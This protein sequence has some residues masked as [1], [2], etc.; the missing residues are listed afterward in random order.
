M[1][2]HTFLQK[3]A[4]Y[5]YQTYQFKRWRKALHLDT[6]AFIYQQLFASVDGFA[7]SRLARMDHDAFDYTYGEIDFIAFI[8][9]LFLAKPNPD[10]VFYDL[11]SGIGTAVLACA[12]VYP[13]K[14]SI[15]IECLLPLH[16]AA[17]Q[18]KNKIKQ[19]A[20]YQHTASIIE[21]IHADFL[22]ASITD[23]TL[24]FINSTAYFG[25]TWDKI[26]QK[27]NTLPALETVLTLSKPL[28]C[29]D[30]KLI[31][32]TRINMS[33]GPVDAYIHQRVTP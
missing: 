24:I 27:L 29:P 15:G 19:Y 12:M 2:I 32:K 26:N 23:A 9:L 22:Q 5:T 25:E 20:T 10:T 33:W 3:I 30:F 13:I 4:P 7:L 8:A 21:F 31:Q 1:H 16:L 6:H 11:G 14:K 18:Q 17:L 28:R